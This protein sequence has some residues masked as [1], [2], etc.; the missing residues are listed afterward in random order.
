MD[1]RGGC[2]R[3]GG[4]TGVQALLLLQR[5]AVSVSETGRREISASEHARGRGTDEPGWVQNSVR[6][7]LCGT[8]EFIPRNQTTPS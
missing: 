2:G 8:A 7:C 1:T 5:G 3:E 6:L 4:R